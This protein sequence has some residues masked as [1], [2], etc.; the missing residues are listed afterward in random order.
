MEGQIERK[1]SGKYNP[2]AV[3]SSKRK[4]QSLRRTRHKKEARR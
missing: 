1:K 4:N 2:G 3:T